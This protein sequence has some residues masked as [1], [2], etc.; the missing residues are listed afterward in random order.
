MNVMGWKGKI[1][2]VSLVVLVGLV[3]YEYSVRNSGPDCR[4]VSY[5]Q[6]IKTISD[7]YY[8]MLQ[9]WHREPKE[10]GTKKPQLN[11][12]HDGTQVTDTYLVPFV[13]TGPSG[14]VKQFAMYVC[15]TGSI[16]YSEQ[17]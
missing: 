15:K 7:D 1:S 13:A 5:E 11:F 4:S 2:F 3:G 12:D 8:E 16:E 14:T 9:R 10:L 6:A 17:E